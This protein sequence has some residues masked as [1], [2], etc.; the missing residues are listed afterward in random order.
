MDEDCDSLALCDPVQRMNCEVDSL[1]ESC[2]DSGLSTLRDSNEY[3]SEVEY[4]HQRALQGSHGTQESFGDDASDVDVPDIRDEETFGAEG[5]A[6]ILDWKPQGSASEG[7]VVCSSRKP[8]SALSPQ[9][10]V[11]DGDHKSSSS[12]KAYKIVLA[13]DAAVGKS[14]FLMRLCKNEFRGNTNATLGLEVSPSLTSEEQTAFCCCM[15]LH[16][17]RAFSMFENGWT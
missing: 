5:V 3:D 13:G 1:P 9:T 15:M 16:A 6:A 12:Q 10:D 4:R 14:S 2:F 7:S 8:I 11:V 17:R